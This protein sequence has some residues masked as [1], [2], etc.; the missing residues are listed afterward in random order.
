MSWRLA[1]A[2]RRSVSMAVVLGC[3]ITCLGTFC[4]A[5][6]ACRPQDEIF[7][8][9]AF[10][11]P[12]GW[13]DLDYKVNNIPNAFDA[14]NTYYFRNTPNLGIVIDG[15]GHFRG[16]TTP[17]NLANGSDDSTGVGY[18]LGGLQYKYHTNRLSPFVRGFVGAA[19]LSPDCCGGRSEEHHV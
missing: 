18:A 5:Q 14:S 10:L 16:G 7:G 11:A 3:A 8:G 6:N 13:G 12:N 9:Y 17:P 15:S 4:S 19:N 1:A 2:G